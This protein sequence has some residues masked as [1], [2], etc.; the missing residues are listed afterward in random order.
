[1]IVHRPEID[2]SPSRP[3][4]TIRR[5]ARTRAT[6]GAAI[7]G[8]LAVV[9]SAC[10]IS[11]DTAP[12]DIASSADATDDDPTTDD[13]EATGSGQVYL[14]QVDATGAPARLMAVPRAVSIGRDRDP[15]EV[16]EVLI[17]GP[18]EGE[19]D[20]NMASFLPPDLQVLGWSSRPGGVVSIDLSAEMAE[21][22]RPTLS[23]ALAQIVYTVTETGG[24]EGVRITVEGRPQEWPDGNEQLRD[25]VL[26]VYDYPGLLRSSQ[27]AFPAIPS[28]RPAA[29]DA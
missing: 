20:D 14:F 25:D 29:P 18:N 21:L 16:L 11:T 24:I 23:A 10:G 2:G 15:T 7:V 17:A 13:N 19:R 6:V 12:R 8:V 3:D 27:P 28:G 5:S 9:L 1:M 4:A 26:T 22:A